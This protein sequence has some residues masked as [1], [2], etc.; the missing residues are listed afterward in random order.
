[1]L[2][3]VQARRERLP[4]A[5]SIHVTQLFTYLLILTVKMETRHPIGDHLTI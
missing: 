2:I 3:S 4:P 5:Y 1:M